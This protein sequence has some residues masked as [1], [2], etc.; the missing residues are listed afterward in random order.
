MNDHRV[1]VI[2]IDLSKNWF[3][4]V[5]IDE[6]GTELF[7]KKLNRGQLAEFSTTT[8][9]CLIAMEACPG[10]QFWGR[11]FQAAGHE[12]CIIPAQF[13]KPYVKS[14]KND[15]NDA[16]AI[17]EAASRGSMRCVP[18]KTTD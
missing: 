1:H 12:R 9:Q 17:A 11:R 4:L 7:R 8:P 13:V 5:A 2:S 14:N 6:R 3:H 10:S 16:Q 15:F 18:L